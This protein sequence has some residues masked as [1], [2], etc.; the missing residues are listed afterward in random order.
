MPEHIEVAAHHL[1]AA[2]QPIAANGAI[3]NNAGINTLLGAVFGFLVLM[4]G[5]KAAHHALRSNLAAVLS[6]VAILAIGVMI[7]NI[8]SAGQANQ[9]GSD[10]VHHLLNI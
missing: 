5:I 7:W 9:L 4:L 8:A 2:A 6:M 3:L 10:L 1:A